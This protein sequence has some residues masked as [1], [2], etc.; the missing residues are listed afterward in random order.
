MCRPTDAIN[1]MKGEKTYYLYFVKRARWEM[2]F[3]LTQTQEQ[4]KY[5]PKN[6]IFV[7]TICTT[8]ARE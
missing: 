2:N 3:G 7:S 5:I 4:G 8:W 6:T 1:H